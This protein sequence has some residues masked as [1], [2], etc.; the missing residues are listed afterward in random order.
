MIT[1]FSQRKNDEHSTEK[2]ADNETLTVRWCGFM[3][4]ID[5]VSPDSTS[6]SP[7]M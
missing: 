5:P 3:A 4:R 6:S 7:A 2:A 1:T